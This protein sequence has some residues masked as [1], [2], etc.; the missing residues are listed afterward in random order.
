MTPGS[1][2][3][4]R[5][6]VESLPLVDS[7]VRSI[8]RRHRLSA[9][10]QDE[11]GA[12]VRLKLV[13]N[14]YEVF[15]KFQGRSQLRTYLITVV[16]RHFLDDRNARWGRWRPS[17][18]AV[19]LG[20]IA[21]LLDQLVTRD[22]LPIEEAAQ[23]IAS[24]HPDAPPTEQLR[25]MLRQ[26]PGRTSRQFLDEDSLENVAAAESGEDDVLNGIEQRRL[27]DR[28]AHALEGVLAGLDDEDRCILR[29]RFCENV[30]LV[31]I[32]ELMRLPQKAFYRRV[33]DL[34]RVLRTALEAQGID[35]ADVANLLHH[36]ETTIAP[37]LAPIGPGKI[38]ERPSVP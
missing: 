37:V 27:G 2:D 36:S 11:L 31:R 20:P 17:A 4:E 29:L 12:S 8:A 35:R 30:K 25:E 32:A 23:V 10:E 3:Y 22:R 33:E 13:E 7:V 28:L 26:L 14:D 19:R 18:Q 16:Q 38:P 5:L 34:M 15:R 21:V 1:V 24:R 6:A 9:D